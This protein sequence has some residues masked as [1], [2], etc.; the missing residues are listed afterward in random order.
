MRMDMLCRFMK[1]HEGCPFCIP[2]CSPNR[3]SGEN[4]PY[5]SDDPPPCIPNRK[6]G[7]DAFS[8]ATDDPS[9]LQLELRG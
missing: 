1:E 8:C 3:G 5:T 4:T 9:I 6:S 7:E 2:P